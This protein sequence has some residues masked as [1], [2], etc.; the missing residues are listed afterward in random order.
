MQW[1]FPLVLALILSRYNSRERTCNAG[2][3]LSKCGRR[4]LPFYYIAVGN[5]LFLSHF[6]KIL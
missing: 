5:P 3:K 4:D 2:I 6:M 1:L